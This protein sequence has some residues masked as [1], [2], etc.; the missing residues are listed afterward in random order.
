MPNCSMI[1]GYRTPTLAFRMTLPCWGSSNRPIW[2]IRGWNS[3][4]SQWNKT[5]TSLAKNAGS[6]AGENWTVRQCHIYTQSCMYRLC[7]IVADLCTASFFHKNAGTRL[8]NL[9][10]EARLK[11]SWKCFC[12]I[13]RSNSVTKRE[14]VPEMRLSGR[15]SAPCSSR[16][17]GGGEGALDR[18][19]PRAAERSDLSITLELLRLLRF[20]QRRESRC[21]IMSWILCVTRINTCVQLRF[22][23]H[24][25]SRTLS[26][27]KCRLH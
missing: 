9:P 10:K 4:V 20:V 14:P 24:D 26:P 1:V 12:G 3:P 16:S 25:N 13:N 17:T 18:T 5:S 2:I 23:N 11:L 21:V 6:L 7:S 8:S 22:L 27:W 19:V 15:E